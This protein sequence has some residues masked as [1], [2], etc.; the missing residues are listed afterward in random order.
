MKFSRFNVIY[1]D[2]ESTWIFNCLSGAFIKINNENMRALGEDIEL[3]DAFK[4]EGILLGDGED[5]ELLKY[6]FLY[7]HAAMNTDSINLAIAPTMQCNFSCHYCFE[8]GNNN[9]SIM[10]QDVEN[11]IVNYLHA[12]KNRN[13]YINWFG[14]EPMMGF[15]RILSITNRLKEEDISFVANMTTNGSLLNKSL[16][17][18]LNTLNLSYIQISLDGIYET[19]DNRRF[20]KNK[21]PSFEIITE[22]IKNLLELTDITLH[23]QVTI[24]R[25]NI[26]AYEDVVA[27]FVKR[28]PTYM[29]GQRILIG[30]NAVLNRTNFDRKSDCL[31]H[32]EVMLLL[33][34][35][36]TETNIKDLNIHLPKPVPSCMYRRTHAF[37]I[38]PDGNMY[39][40]LEHLGNEKHRIGNIKNAS[41]SISNIAQTTFECDP[42]EDDCCLSCNILPI[43]AGGCPIDRIR[44]KNDSNIN[45]CSAYKTQIENLLPVIYNSYK[46]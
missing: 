4:Q 19:H 22:N 16:L 1:S 40:C 2:N 32:N 5:T 8:D 20:F 17:S 31:T 45:Y 6:K 25:T 15:K 36:I 7:Y 30:S 29:D 39:K 14:G 3:Q 37:A 21:K 24:D 18:L 35:S 13:I 42:F 10:N 28:F 27:Y 41:L 26:D 44:K 33:Q 12:H 11:A 46:L 23:I 43:C 9:Q 38:D 34:K